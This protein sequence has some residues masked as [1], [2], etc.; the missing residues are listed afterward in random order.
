MLR[1]RLQSRKFDPMKFHYGCDLIAVLLAK[2]IKLRYRGTIL[3]VFWSL[4]NPLAFALVLY[5]AFKQV[6][7]IEIE[8]YPLFILSALFPW[9]WISNSVGA[10][11]MLFIANASLIK[12][13][14]FPRAA[15]AAAVVLNDM[16]H[17][18]IT[19]PIFIA[20]LWISSVGAPTWSW[21]VGVPVLLLI[22]SSLTTALIVILGLAN[23]F[24]RDL[25]QLVRVLLL[26]MFYV[27]PILYPV[28]M[29]PPQLE[30]LMILNPFA[31][32]LISWRS[33][34]IENQLSP[35]ILTA[36]VHA[37][38]A[39]ALAYFTYKKTAWRLAEVI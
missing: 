5:V 16:I 10:G 6:L 15:L 27:T 4:A 29:V 13:L 8:N 21:V 30:W 23:A 32:L 11:P 39:G 3:G 9:Q 12:R 38:L 14:P 31:P 19:I 2:E 34:L 22:Q 17:F 28:K 7:R 24:F 1:A 35:Y 37:A 33:L 26:L 20:L 25:D 36:L 18:V